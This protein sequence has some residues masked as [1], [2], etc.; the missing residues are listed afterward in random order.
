MQCRCVSELNDVPLYMHAL[1]FFTIV[2]PFFCRLTFL[3]LQFC[4]L[5][6]QH[7]SA[8][9]NMQMN[10]N[11]SAQSL[12]AMKYSPAFHRV[13]Q[14]CSKKL[15]GWP[16]ANG[17]ILQAL[18]ATFGSVEQSHVP[19]CMLSDPSIHVKSLSYCFANSRISRNWSPFCARAN[20]PPSLKQ[21]C[22]AASHDASKS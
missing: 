15:S 14:S 10:E 2:S 12:S 4:C 20:V 17:S 22:L 19:S 3:V 1:Q 16:T 6:A 13:R 21:M 8:F 18:P 7:Y 11:I 9:L 5:S